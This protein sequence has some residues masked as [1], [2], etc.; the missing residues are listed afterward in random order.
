[1][2]WQQD[3]AEEI[4]P[5]PDTTAV[6]RVSTAVQT[7]HCS[8]TEMAQ[9]DQLTGFRENS[10]LTGL[11]LVAQSV[12]WPPAVQ[13][14]QARSLEERM[15]TH[16]SILAWRIPMDRGAWQATVHGVRKSQTWLFF[17]LPYI[18]EKSSKFLNLRYLVFFNS[19]LL[20]F[21]LPCLCYK[22][23]HISWSL[24]YLFGAVS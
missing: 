23:H 22:N 14:R 10:A 11:S 9:C 5:S 24:P 15:A 6:S 4:V 7:V 3:W 17:I 16:T 21:W 2:L 8:M 12:K 13:E 19:N 18:Q 1:M 20:K